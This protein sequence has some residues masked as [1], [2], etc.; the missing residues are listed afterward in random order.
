MGARFLSHYAEKHFGKGNKLQKYIFIYQ[1]VEKSTYK[2]RY[3]V[4]S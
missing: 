4:M 1:E 2:K 3:M